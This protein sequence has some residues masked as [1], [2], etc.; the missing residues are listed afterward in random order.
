MTSKK[1]IQE[2]C[3]RIYGMTLQEAFRIDRERMREC[4]PGRVEKADRI[5]PENGRGL[6]MA[7]GWL[8]LSVLGLKNEN[9]LKYTEKGK[10]YAPGYPLFN[11]SHSGEMAVM[12]VL[13]NGNC[14]PA[15]DT[16]AGIWLISEGIPVRGIST[17][18]VDTEQIRERNCNL[19]R[20]AFT[21]NEQTWLEEASCREDKMKRFMQIWT[22]KEAVMKADGRGLGMD[23]ASF[24]VLDLKD[25]LTLVTDS[26]KWHALSLEYEGHMISVCWG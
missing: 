21:E 23:P 17:L 2:G 9:E 22:L 12:A 14:H 11:L 3:I 4:M 16:E 13:E 26:R 8:M 18:G 7:A 24:D 5:R 1:E 19:I 10:P 15:A 20:R 25:G 6:C